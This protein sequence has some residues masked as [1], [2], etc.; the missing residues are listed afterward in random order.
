MADEVRIITQKKGERF[1]LDH[2]G[3][4]LY[5][6]REYPAI[7]HQVQGELVHTTAKPLMHMVCWEEE[8]SMNVAA[9]VAVV[10]DRENP[11]EVRM[12]HEFVGEHRQTHQIE[13]FEHTM[14]IPT[15]P[16]EPIHHALQMQTPLELRFCNP[17]QVDSSYRVEVAMG[18]RQLLTI[19]L[20]GTSVCR[21]QPCDDRP[22][23]N[24]TDPGV[25]P[26][27]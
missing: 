6:D 12:Q 14:R 22:R 7:G 5:G 27:G 23:P 3:V 10:G 21:P 18:R 25:L 8:C 24:D 15:R 4:A 17:W 11:V 20:Q 26:V 16:A 1:A 13:P 19:R 9:R 2:D